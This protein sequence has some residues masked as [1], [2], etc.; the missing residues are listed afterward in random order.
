[1]FSHPIGTSPQSIL[2]TNLF[3]CL[4]VE[5]TRQCEKQEEVLSAKNME[6]Q[7]L[8]KRLRE[9]ELMYRKEMSEADIERKQQRYIAKLLEEDERKRSRNVAG[10]QAIPKTKQ[11]KR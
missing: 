3:F 9:Q 7:C 8:E 2:S 1:M 4:I 11:K 5:I 10:H 6:I